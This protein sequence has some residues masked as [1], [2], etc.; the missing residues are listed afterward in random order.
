MAEQSPPIEVVSLDRLATLL[1]VGVGTAERLLADHRITP[2]LS[3]DG[4]R[5]FPASAVEQLHNPE[6]SDDVEKN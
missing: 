4:R 1:N 6:G 3:V 2:R 5:Y